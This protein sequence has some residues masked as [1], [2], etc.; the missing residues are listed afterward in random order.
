MTLGPQSPTL[1][2]TRTYDIMVHVRITT[3]TSAGIDLC[4]DIRRDI[5]YAPQHT[6]VS[7]QMSS[8][9]RRGSYCFPAVSYPQ[10]SRSPTK[11]R[12]RLHLWRRVRKCKQLSRITPLRRPSRTMGSRTSTEM[13]VRTY[14]PAECT[15]RSTRPTR[16]FKQEVTFTTKR[17]SNARSTASNV[18][19]RDITFIEH[20]HG[21]TQGHFV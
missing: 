12:S 5:S 18:Y 7:L 15:A 1:S 19:D 9:L 4:P 6:C 21:N 17:I 16:G 10:S 13:K 14:L 2:D 3:W 11:W 20:G 8:H